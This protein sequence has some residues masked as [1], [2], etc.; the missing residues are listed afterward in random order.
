MSY[1][2]QLHA[3]S[4]RPLTPRQRK[5]AQLVAADELEDQ[6]IA[7]IVGVTPRAIV[8]WKKR[9]DFMAEVNGILAAYSAKVMRRGVALRVKRVERLNDLHDRSCRVIEA[10]ASDPA[11][12]NVPGGDTGMVV[13]SYRNIVNPKTGKL[14]GA[15]VH[16]YDTGIVRSIL[17]IQKQAAQELGQWAPELAVGAGGPIKLTVV[18]GDKETGERFGVQAELGAGIR[19]TPQEAD[20]ESIGGFRI[21][22]QEEGDQ[23]RPTRGQDNGSGDHCG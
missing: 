19:D 3:P 12:A 21:R 20:Q 8:S 15:P 1:A 11:L 5:A 6:Q 22:R 13:K 7:A 2:N 4:C 10:R 16:E 23:G 18:Y 14:I 9:E 17:D